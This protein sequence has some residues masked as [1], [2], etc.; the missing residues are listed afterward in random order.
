MVFSLNESRIREDCSR[1][2]LCTA[3]SFLA[4]G[5]VDP[6]LLLLTLI[7]PWSSLLMSPEFNKTVQ[8][9]YFALLLH[10]LLWVR[11]VKN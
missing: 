2:V 9:R 3:S 4:V 1:Q 11:L 8:D 10:F 7:D 6:E 5:Q